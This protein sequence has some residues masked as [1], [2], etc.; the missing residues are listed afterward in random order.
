MALL[1]LSLSFS[2][3]WIQNDLTNNPTRRAI[4]N[5][6]DAIVQPVRRSTRIMALQQQ[7]NDSKNTTDDAKASPNRHG[8]AA[9]RSDALS[10]MALTAEEPRLRRS[11]RFQAQQHQDILR[12]DS[13][14]NLGDFTDPKSQLVRRKSARTASTAP[15]TND[16]ISNGN[17]HS[18]GTVRSSA[19]SS[20]RQK[21]SANGSDVDCF[22][23]PNGV[24][25]TTE[26]GIPPLDQRHIGNVFQVPEYASQ[27][28]QYL[29]I[30]ETRFSVNSYTK[31]HLYLREVDRFDAI[32]WL[33][34]LATA[35]KCE[36]PVVY[37]SIQILDRYLSGVSVQID[38]LQ[39]VAAVTLMLASKYEEVEALTVA[40]LL[41]VINHDTASEVVETERLILEHIHYGTHGLIRWIPRYCE[42]LL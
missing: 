40:H 11:S 5:T 15:L 30:M 4:D 35:Y 9:T 29:Y 23:L 6:E 17:R 20:K 19:S 14:Q 16:A 36:E 12:R 28:Y 32:D 18:I 24:P 13:L 25:G 39:M 37:L 41:M 10:V 42:V 38:D 22:A 26:S 7:H 8:T 1:F 34:K 21:I 33:L 2:L 27:I 31:T 3:E